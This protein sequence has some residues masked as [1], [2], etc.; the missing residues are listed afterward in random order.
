MA[1]S[2]FDDGPGKF[3]H[4]SD[5]LNPNQRLDMISKKF[6]LTVGN[7]VDASV[8]I[9]ENYV[10]IVLSGKDLHKGLTHNFSVYDED[11]DEFGLVKIS[12][13]DERW[14]NK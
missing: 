13:Q 10:S 8:M 14:F 11:Y 12:A 5:P 6:N 4:K 9:W 1:Y 2:Y 3:Y 7:S